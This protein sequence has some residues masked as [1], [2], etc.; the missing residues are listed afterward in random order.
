MKEPV[1]DNMKD[2]DFE[3]SAEDTA[4]ENIN[5]KDDDGNALNKR[6]QYS[7]QLIM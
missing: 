7:W 6:N 2:G 5:G 1:C 3:E 4:D